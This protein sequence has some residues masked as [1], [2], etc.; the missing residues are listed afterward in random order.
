M[1]PARDP[2]VTN[3]ATGG[4]ISSTYPFRLDARRAHG[5]RV[6]SCLLVCILYTDSER[7]SGAAAGQ[8]PRRVFV[9]DGGV[10]G[11]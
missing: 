10:V 9:D 5:L 6:V 7:P 1:P 4:R 11:E 3:K 2:A 8:E